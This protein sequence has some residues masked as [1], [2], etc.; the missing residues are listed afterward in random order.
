MF[1]TDFLVIGS[2]IAGLS[3]ALK[4]AEHGKVCII[5]K[6]H[7]A[8]SNTNYAQGGI[9]AVLTPEDSFDKHIEDTLVA[10]ADLCDREIVEIVVKEGPERVRELIAIGA[11]FTRQQDGE[12]H[13]GREGGHSV[14]RIIHAADTTGRV[15]EQALL[16]QIEKHSNITVLEYYFATDLLMNQAGQCVGALVMNEQ[17]RES[18]YVTAQTTLLASGGSGQVYA[19]TTNPAIATGDGVAMAVRAGAEVANM[20]FFQFH[21]T[22]LYHPDCNSF[23]ISEAVRGEGGVLKNAA[24]ERFMLQYHESAELAPRDIVARAIDDQLKRA[25][26][27][28]VYL[29]ISHQSPEFITSHFPTIASTCERFGIDITK[30]AIPVVPAAHYQCGGV[31]SDENAKTSLPGLLVCGEVAYTGLHGANRLASNSLLEALVFSHRAAL[32]SVAEVA[33]GTRA[34]IEPQPP[35]AMKLPSESVTT[36]LSNYQARIKRIMWKQVGIIRNN[37]RLKKAESQLNELQRSFMAEFGEREISDTQF[38]ETRNMII[39]AQLIVTS[40]LMRKE[41][42]GLH[43]NSDY[44]ALSEKFSRPTHV[45]WKGAKENA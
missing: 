36:S 42:R 31:V 27:E 29:D 22:S 11:E 35:I 37:E 9:A 38:F 26:E 41:S 14:N 6:K 1:H 33:I 4:V 32:T 13:Y 40:A 16:H 15:V 10:G 18:S 8:E 30:E 2:G 28:C 23:L 20:E 24:G 5:T 43:S 21:P 34:D 45:K 39:N 17:S 3:Y 12:L 7:S 19:H 25:N 44:P